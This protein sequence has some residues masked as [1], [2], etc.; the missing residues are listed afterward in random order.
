V[1]TNRQREAIT[2]VI[3]V[4]AFSMDDSVRDTL[5]WPSLEWV[6]ED[7]DCANVAGH[8]LW[9]IPNCFMKDLGSLA[10]RKNSRSVDYYA[11]L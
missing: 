2:H 3:V 1:R 8:L 10:M 4:I 7:D 6:P 11:S 9:K 5:D